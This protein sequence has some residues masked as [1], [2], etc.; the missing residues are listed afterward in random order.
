MHVLIT[1][2]KICLKEDKQQNSVQFYKSQYIVS[3]FKINHNVMIAKTLR[4]SNINNSNNNI[5]NS[6]RL[7]HCRRDNFA[8]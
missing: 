6:G 8:F 7:W 1:L 5:R 4:N 3:L 2:G